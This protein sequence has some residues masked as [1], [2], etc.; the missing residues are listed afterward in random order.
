M[1]WRLIDLTFHWEGACWN[2]SPE[3]AAPARRDHVVFS[4]RRLSPGRLTNHRTPPTTDAGTHCIERALGAITLLGQ[5]PKNKSWGLPRTARYQE[6]LPRHAAALGGIF[7]EWEER[8]NP[9]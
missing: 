9:R 2:L 7:K 6:C 5:E 8:K 1:K 3:P 4:V